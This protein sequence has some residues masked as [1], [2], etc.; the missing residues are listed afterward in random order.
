MKS[1]TAKFNTLTI[2]LIVFTALATGSYMVWKHQVSA[3]DNFT[4]H[5]K[6]TAVMLSR[7]IEYG[8]YTENQQVLS[9]AVQG[10]GENPDIAYLIVS[11]KKKE[12]LIQRDFQKLQ[13]LPS[14][15]EQVILLSEKKFVINNFLDP[16]N[17]R[18]I[19]NIVVPVYMLAMKEINNF[20]VGLANISNQNS[21]AELIGYLQ[22]GISQDRI[23]EDS[24]QF[25]LQMLFIYPLILTLCI[26][27]MFWQTKR[28][29]RPINELV[30]ATH[31]IT[32]GEFGRQVVP[33]SKDEI[34][35]LTLAF[36]GMSKELVNYKK[37]E[38][39][40]RKNLEEQVV[41]R[42][43]DLQ[44]KTDE[45]YQLA[46]KAQAA[47][48]AKSEFLATMSHE[49]RT[50]MNG[51]LGMTELLLATELN[52]RQKRL[53][54]IAYRSAESLLGI[55]NNILDFS[56]FESGSFQLINNDFDLRELLED[57]AEVL[58]MQA[59]TKGLELLLN[60]PAD[61]NAIVRGDG[62]RLRQVLLN[63]LGNAIKF[64]YHGEVQLKVSWFN[65]NDD[66]DH[67]HLSFE[68]IDTGPGI[69]A[70]QQKNVF[71]SF[72][73]EDG[74]I[75]RRHGGTGLG[76]SIS[77][78]VVQ[79]M[80]GELQLT[81]TL[82]QGACFS[83]NLDLE[84]S[85]QSVPKK[86][87]ISAL[88]GI[89]ILVVDD[90]ATNREILSE[91][92]SSWGVYS[93]CA[94]SGAQ[95]L[96]HLLDA[97]KNN[98]TYQVALLDWHMPEMDGMALA[99]AIQDEPQLPS[100]PLVMLSS[101]SVAFDHNQSRRY[102]INYFLNKPV[103]QQKLLNCL[104]NLIGSLNNASPN[105]AKPDH[106]KA[107][108]LTGKILLAEDN[109]V[110]Q[111]VGIAMLGAIGY[112]V[113][114]VNNGLEAVNAA[115]GNLYDLILIDCHMPEMDGFQ[116]TSKIRERE[117]TQ[118]DQSRVPI[119]AL[120]ADVQKGI[121]EQ[122]LDAGMDDYLSK[123]FNKKQLQ[124]LLEKWLHF[125]H[126]E[127]TSHLKS[128]IKQTPS[129]TEFDVNNL[130]STALN[131]L[132][133]ITTETGENLLIKA[134]K[135]FVATAPKEI[136]ALQHAADIEDSA[137]LTRIAHSFKSAC[138]NLGAQSLADSAASIGA[139]AKQGQ[140]SGVDVLLKTIKSELPDVLLALHQEADKTAMEVTTQPI[141]TPQ[142]AKLS[143]RILLVDDDSSFRIITG[144]VLTASAFIVNEAES[145]L[146]AIENAKQQKPD[147]VLL[148]AVMDELDGFETCKL[149]RENPEMVDVPIIM[150]TGLGDIDS[151]NRAFE[152][153]A[154]DF[155]VKPLNYPI[156]IH[157]LW[158]ILRADENSSELRSSKLQL[159]TA[160][161]IA[162]LGDWIWDVQNN[163]FQL[164]E[165]LAELC[166]VDLQSFDTSL[167]GFVQLI[168]SEDQ[169]M[170][171]NMILAAPY[172]KTIQHIEYRLKGVN[173]STIFVH[174]EMV[175]IIENNQAKITGTVQDISQK[176]E[177][178][179]QI[180]HLAYFDSLTG[181]PSRSYYQER[182]K[183]IIQT[184]KHR[185][186]Q[187]AF[188]FLDLDGFKDINDSFGHNVGDQLLIVIAQRLQE[189]I[190]D[191][192]FAARLGGDEFCIILNDIKGIES[193]TE[194]ANRCLQ[195]I[196]APLLLNN[197]QL[198][199][200]VS[201]GI[202]IFPR[203][204]NNE[205][206][207]LKAAD[208]AM[209]AAKE[210]GKQCF[211]FYSKDMAIQAISRLEKEQML[212]EAF[213]KEQFSLYYQ[214]QI[215]LHTGR[216]IGV[217][218]LA[219]W[220]HPEQGMIPPS[221]FIPLMERLGL[222]ADF[223]N[224]V[225][226]SACEQIAQWHDAGLPYL[227]VAVNISPLH[228]KDASLVN[229]VKYLL[230][231]NSVSARYLEL[232]V[233]ES[234]LQTEGHIEVFEQL[235]QLGIKISIDDFG[236]GY[237]CLASLKQLPLDCIKIDK[238]FLDDVVTNTHTALLLGAIIGLANA[239][240]YKL[241]AEGIE[242]KEQLL[243]MHGMG[244][245]IIQGYYFSRPVAS[246]KIPELME[247]DFIR[248]IAELE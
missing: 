153:G 92:L 131:N 222:I 199:P 160:Q 184:A 99:K 18:S 88:Q 129:N 101:D 146:Q 204:G 50:T 52:I 38:V 234:A 220:Q 133:E 190:R 113:E 201:I 191:V 47:S 192:D 128:A 75:T 98:R 71:E 23:Y 27:L 187:F 87:D 183:A 228:F 43:H 121:V 9:Q 210:A 189:V 96:N 239:L 163:H 196:N 37:E 246:D 11:N 74:S 10:L 115:A 126:L 213:E 211:A 152:C 104:L 69:A 157:R 185:D 240:D 34:A 116:A 13:Q 180:H 125:K 109:L 218:A 31:E 177:N 3:F 142:F 155:M 86:A 65:K 56:K 42:T 6:E 179:K 215:S 182:I 227:Q 93:Y 170:V 8:V 26:L 174:Q 62:A 54:D 208:T 236:T 82:G 178:E 41:Q 7:N 40:Q 231:K 149:L 105:Q 84:R 100:L 94:A 122:C 36:N 76:L 118:N 44:L 203:D 89:N 59:H 148:D 229:T 188:L 61:L 20:E 217:E 243:I 30:S 161:R 172:K 45:A 15:T 164:S 21:N 158:F 223:G 168:Y 140:I 233:T 127:P 202:A 132:R 238:I 167:E 235:R 114:M 162:R 72:T 198:K 232:E 48:K 144:S 209:Y 17:S 181:I 194:I 110:N 124:D 53:A 206:A 195:K 207:L 136:D 66:G 111:Q 14:I 97:K 214:P 197:S 186:E 151:I 241:V 242:T 112:Q 60:V 103:I 193:V 107:P 230:E 154:T 2:F 19:I 90:N 79:M 130:N 68:V 70:E 33:T 248:Q 4:Q 225:I 24:M 81:S 247:I 83:F 200:R 58:A 5:G 165:Q 16:S 95:A 175:K 244:C 55:I 57:T 49:I 134:V 138:A 32:N 221:E 46:D 78:Q 102:G 35:E 85:A 73:R 64:T 119:I 77:K 137:A 39:N 143:K 226:K 117:S 91:L 169:G 224:W 51:V 106:S 212:R 141:T 171:K 173:A 237:S 139:I 216:M 108:K 22:L 205:V 245:H 29:T 63:L 135:L 219:R 67:M 1:I 156:L 166:G 80:G 120:T 145:G 25:I 28:I 12:V 159:S 176:K 123:P 150:V 147:L